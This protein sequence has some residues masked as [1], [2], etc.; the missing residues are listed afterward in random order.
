MFFWGSQPAEAEE[1]AS[2]CE[3]LAEALSEFCSVVRRGQAAQG[4]EAQ[5]LTSS[6]KLSMQHLLPVYN[7]RSLGHWHAL[8]ARL[9]VCQARPLPGSP[10]PAWKISLEDDG[11]H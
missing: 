9:P 7:V 8:H 5:L 1:E 6:G 10:W 2:K 3:A 4:D 11:D